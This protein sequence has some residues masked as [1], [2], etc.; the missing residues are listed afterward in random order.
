MSITRLR[1]LDVK[2]REE[3]SLVQEVVN[4]KF[5]AKVPEVYKL[6]IPDIKTPEEE[7]LW[8][9]KVDERVHKVKEKMGLL[10]VAD[11]EVPEVV[12]DSNVPEDMTLDS[13]TDRF[14]E[15]CDSKGVRHLKS[16]TRPN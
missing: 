10:D 14:C 6:D 4:S 11:I 3:E 5:M 8:Q 2:D 1:S 9:A 16:C 13:K 15:F 7:A 12:T